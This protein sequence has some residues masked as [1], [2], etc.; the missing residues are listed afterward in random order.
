MNVIEALN[1]RRST[2]AFLPAQIEKDKL[3]AVLEAASRTPSWANSQPWET[4]VAAGGAL[5]RIR[6]AYREKYAQS[7]KPE[8]E[9]PRPTQWTEA[10]IKRR[11]EMHP[12]LVRDAGEA[13]KQF[14]KLNQAMFHAPAVIFICMDKIL[15]EWSLY[16]I[17][18]YAQSIML[19]AAEYGLATI[20]AITLMH[21]PDVIR[22]ELAIPENLKLTIGIAIGYAD[23]ENG[24]NRFVSDRRSFEEIVRFVE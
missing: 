9:T 8:P 17:G 11:E 10:A 18:A 2:R 4:F 13:A 19:A 1:A 16:D 15:S 20:P 21:F 7:A 23:T 12:G 24:I 5:E 14:G 3:F 6:E 22:R